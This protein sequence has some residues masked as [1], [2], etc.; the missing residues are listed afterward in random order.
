MPRT[1]LPPGCF[2]LLLG[3]LAIGCSSSLPGMGYPFATFVCML[4]ARSAILVTAVCWARAARYDLGGLRELVM[5]ED[6]LFSKCGMRSGIAPPLMHS[7]THLTRANLFVR[8]AAWHRSCE[9]AAAP[10]SRHC[11]STMEA[12]RQVCG[13]RGADR[14]LVCIGRPCSQAAYACDAAGCGGGGAPLASS[15]T[16]ARANAHQPCVLGIAQ[17]R[18]RTVITLRV[19]S[20]PFSCLIGLCFSWWL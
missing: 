15:H 9:G 4:H 17:R 11:S 10:H 19:A 18:V 14:C 5:G 12:H 6:A 1:L 8:S 7:T 20:L 2:M 16:A 13:R 3:K